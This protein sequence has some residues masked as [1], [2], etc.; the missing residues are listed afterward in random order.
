MI[1]RAVSVSPP[2]RRHTDAAHRK[3]VVLPFRTH[4]LACAALE[5]LWDSLLPENGSAD[6]GFAAV[7]LV[8]VSTA[9]ITAGKQT[10]ELFRGW[11]WGLEI[12]LT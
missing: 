6:C 11:M 12:R 4:S 8:A 7:V 3:T 9:L 2:S 10:T 1:K 5:G